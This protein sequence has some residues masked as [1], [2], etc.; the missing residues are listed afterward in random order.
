MLACLFVWCVGLFG[1][2]SLWGEEN[3]VFLQK[4]PFPRQVFYENP[5][6]HQHERKGFVQVE[7]DN[8]GNALFY[9]KDQVLLVLPLSRISAIVPLPP[10]KSDEYSL[11]DL[12]W[13]LSVCSYQTRKNPEI[14]EI[15]E[16]WKTLVLEKGKSNEAGRRQNT[17]AYNKLI[18]EAALEKAAEELAGVQKS[19]ENYQQFS[20]RH[21]IQD[22]L[23]MINRLNPQLFDDQEQ[24]HNAKRYWENILALPAQIPVPTQWPYQLP[25]EL[26]F[27]PA[28]QAVQIPTNLAA[29]V[30]FFSSMLFS[31]ALLSKTFAALRNHSFFPAVLLGALFL[32]FFSSF[33]GVFFLMQTPLNGVQLVLFE[34]LEWHDKETISVR[35]LRDKSDIHAEVSLPLGSSFYSLPSFFEFDPGFGSAP[36]NLRVKKAFLGTFQL[37]KRFGEWIWSW[38]SESYAWAS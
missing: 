36:S 32:A 29:M 15:T 33:V 14:N 31:A 34:K 22:N 3:D 25:G 7:T 6:T 5:S 24:L 10:E 16:K 18:R 1:V 21:Q 13:A 27:A 35:L 26:F 11:E 17:E 20:Q 8:Q 23:E 28:P 2:F 19:V 4:S 37:P 9:L 38:L 30:I 12:K